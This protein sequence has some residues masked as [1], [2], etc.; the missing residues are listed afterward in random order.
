MVPTS[1]RRNGKRDEAHADVL[2]LWR[3]TMRAAKAVSSTTLR[4]PVLDRLRCRVAQHSR[5]SQRCE[6]FLVDAFPV[7]LATVHLS[8]RNRRDGSE[9]PIALPP[10]AAEGARSSPTD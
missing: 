10:R 5:Q 1:P 7:T 3:A 6:E 2:A 9:L 4:R 8:R